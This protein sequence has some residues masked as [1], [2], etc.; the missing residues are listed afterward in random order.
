MNFL[1]DNSVPRCEVRGA[2]Q[3][4][5]HIHFPSSDAEHPL[6]KVLSQIVTSHACAE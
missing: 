1:I 2:P 5:G 3:K 4:S 6:E